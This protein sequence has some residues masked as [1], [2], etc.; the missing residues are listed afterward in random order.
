MVSGASSLAWLTSIIK[1]VIWASDGV[2]RAGAERV[3][4]ALWSSDRNSDSDSRVSG[5][6]KK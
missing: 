1:R 5:G 2:V 3:E 4:R 6:C